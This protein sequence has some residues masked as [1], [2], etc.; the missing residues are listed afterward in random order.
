MMRIIST[1]FMSSY[2]MWR[3]GR[4]IVKI[5]LFIIGTPAAVT[6][7]A[8]AYVEHIGGYCYLGVSSRE[9][10]KQCLKDVVR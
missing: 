10:Y 7:A 4:M 5:L 3:V 6:A 9:H 2:P 8:K 1:I